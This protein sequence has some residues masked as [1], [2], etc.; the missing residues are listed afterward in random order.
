MGL[1]ELTSDERRPE[2]IPR[3][4]QR[5]NVSGFTGTNL[6]RWAIELALYRPTPPRAS[7]VCYGRLVAKNREGWPPL[8]PSL[9]SDVDLHGT[10]R[11]H[12]LSKISLWLSTSCSQLAGSEWTV[13]ST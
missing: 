9:S 10:T 12:D 5:S 11:P 6:M 7:E 8:L 3:I 1:G 4:R 2:V 13:A